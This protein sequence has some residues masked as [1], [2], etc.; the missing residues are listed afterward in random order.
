MIAKPIANCIA[1]LRIQPLALELPN[2]LRTLVQKSCDFRGAAES[3]VGVA[4]SYR[5]VTTFEQELPKR[6]SC[7]ACIF[8]LEQEKCQNIAKNKQI[9]QTTM[10]LT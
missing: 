10:S 4:R 1:L 9:C 5:T 7:T 2:T 6:A 8:Q 3:E